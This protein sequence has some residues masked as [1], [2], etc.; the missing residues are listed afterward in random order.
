MEL[1]RGLGVVTPEDP[2]PVWEGA[3]GPAVIAPLFLLYD[4]TFRPDGT[5]TK[6]EGLAEAYQAGVVATDEVLLLPDPYP[7]IDAWCAARLAL[8]RAPAGRAASRDADRAGQ[9]LPAG[10]GADPGAAVSGVRAVVRH[11]GARRTGPRGFNAVAVVYG[12]LHI[13]RT[14]WH[15]G[16]RHEEVS[17]GYPR[18]WQRRER[19]PRYR[20]RSS[21]TVTERRAALG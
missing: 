18:E 5:T 3:G 19:P 2:Y 6:A 11:D 20:A 14:T 4:Y 10:Q 21:R 12:H 8:D 1:C 7:S 16:I 15:D 17:L 9:S 13:P